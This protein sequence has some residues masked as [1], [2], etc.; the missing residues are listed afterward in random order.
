[1]IS[2]KDL[3][4][5][6]ARDQ[7]WTALIERIAIGEQAALSD[8]YEASSRLVYGLIMRIVGDPATAEEVLL[9]AYTQVWRQAS[10]YDR[11]RGSPL[12][13][14][15]TIG[16]TRALDRLRAGRQDQQRR[17][18]FDAVVETASQ[19]ENPEEMTALGERR[20]LVRE[21]LQSL[22]AEQREALELAYYGGLSHSEIALRLELPLGTVKT[23]IRLGMN[24]LREQLRP[25][26]E[27]E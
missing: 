2:P 23:R 10:S 7:D 24:R 25:L 15:M 20:R 27:S 4:E 17:E 9:D 5:W 13:W 3:N 1:M 14:L 19:S 16:R 8:L 22:T 12:A 11:Q 26:L 18:P 21:A 6:R